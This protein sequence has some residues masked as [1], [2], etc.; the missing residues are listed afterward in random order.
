MFFE[1]DPKLALSTKA[2]LEQKNLLKIVD[3][4]KSGEI[5]LSTLLFHWPKS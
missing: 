1:I 2:F 3:E 5:E 4:Q